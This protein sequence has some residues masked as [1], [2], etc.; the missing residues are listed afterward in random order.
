MENSGFVA[1]IPVVQPRPALSG[2]KALPNGGQD[3]SYRSTEHDGDALVLLFQSEAPPWSEL[4]C[5]CVQ[6]R[7]QHMFADSMPALPQAPAGILL[8]AELIGILFNNPLFY[9]FHGVKHT[10]LFV[11]I[12]GCA[13]RYLPTLLRK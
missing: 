8:S 3:L 12:N 9:P 10:L 5:V 6:M 2:P 1:L 11:L 7:W 4:V 13:G